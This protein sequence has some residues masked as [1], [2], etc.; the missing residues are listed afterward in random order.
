MNHIRRTEGVPSCSVQN[1]CHPERSLTTSE[2]SR[3]TQSKDPAYSESAT[4]Q[5]GNFQVVVRFFDEQN[6]EF[7]HGPSREAA[8]C[9]SP[10]RQCRVSNQ[11]GIESRR[12]ATPALTR[13]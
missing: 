10:A 7:Q 9:E 13:Q 3:Q 8:E 2:T 5:A 12:D 6:A 4:G 11:K 1:A